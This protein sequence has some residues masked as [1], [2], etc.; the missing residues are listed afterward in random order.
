MSRRPRSFAVLATL[1][2]TVP[3]NGGVLPSQTA[4]KPS[5]AAA[6]PQPRAV[7]FLT[8]DQI[9]IHG[10]YGPSAGRDAKAPAVILL[11]MY[12]KDRSGFDP[13][14]PVLRE[15][16]FAVL[17]IDMRGHGQSTGPPAMNLP[18]RVADRDSKLFREMH[19]DVRAAYLWLAGQPE[20][21]TA[22]FALIGASVGCSVALDYAARDRSVDAVVCLT[23]GTS[24]LGIDSLR[25]ARKYG[26][27]A[28]LLLAAEPERS[29]AQTLAGFVPG[30]TLQIVPGRADNE[31]ALHGTNMLGQVP[32]VEEFIIAFLRGALGPPATQPVFASIN[33]DIY[34]HADSPSVRRITKE[35]LRQFSSPAEAESRGLR[36]SKTALRKSSL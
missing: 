27:R 14:L 7:K 22:R 25:D 3:A 19:R 17:A 8:D 35:N 6:T 2:L 10:T 33:S 5:G 4:T 20:V 30:A 32:K 12:N 1:A 9:E 16:G 29:A 24:Y 13:L 31:M 15:A 21:D 28:L 23:P 36:P 11:H 26:R 34:H 18:R